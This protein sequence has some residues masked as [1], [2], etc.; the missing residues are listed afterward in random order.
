MVTI[1]LAVNEAVDIKSGKTVK[2]SLL[3]QG[4]MFL[5]FYCNDLNKLVSIIHLILPVSVS[6]EHILQKDP[7]PL[8]L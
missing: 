2:V 8:S 1:L 5:V 6:S 7:D 3:H 4:M